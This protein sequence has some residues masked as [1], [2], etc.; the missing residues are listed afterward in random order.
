MPDGAAAP[1]VRRRPP[2][3][4]LGALVVFL[5]LPF[6]ALFL[7]GPLAGAL[8]LGRPRSGRQWLTL[9]L[10]I[11]LTAIAAGGTGS[12]GHQVTVA[13]GAVFT[14]A[15]LAAAVWRPGPA[16]PRAATAAVVTAGFMAVA[17]AWVGLGWLEVRD[18][19]DQDWQRGLAVL[20]RMSELGGEQEHA[21]REAVTALAGLYP[22]LAFLGALAGGTL[23]AALAAHAGARPVF[24]E[25]G[26]FT[27]FRF[28]DHLVWG[29][30]AALA[31]V[32]LQPPAPWDDL[33]ASHLL[34]WAGLY[35]ARGA[36]IWTGRSRG[37][38]APVRIALFLS[39]VLLLPYAVGGLMIL[40][41]ADTWV[42]FRREPPPPGGLAR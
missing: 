9:G 32:L 42:D 2:R 37:W 40:G 18:A 34:V 12:L 19:I 10:V 21:M 30:V 8:A 29:G 36:A 3:G 39:A 27:G 14:G 33:A 31:A 17:T 16:L 35:A 24:P 26:P 38:P 28:N 1:P 25:P 7:L 11:L 5:V 6:P 22:G 41:L 15:F 20:A 4:L 23:A 13:A